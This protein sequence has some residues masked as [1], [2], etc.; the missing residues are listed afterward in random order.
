MVQRVTII[1]SMIA[2]LSQISNTFH[3]ILYDVK[4]CVIRKDLFATLFFTKKKFSA[5]FSGRPCDSVLEAK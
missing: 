5:V 4:N 3:V 1:K 2:T